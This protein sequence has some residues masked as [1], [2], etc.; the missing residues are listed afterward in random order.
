MPLPPT[1]SSESATTLQ[2]QTFGTL[3][4]LFYWMRV[5]RSS[6]RTPGMKF[7]C[8]MPGHLF[9]GSPNCEQT[10]QV[11]IL[12]IPQLHAIKNRFRRQEPIR[13]VTH[14]N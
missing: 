3:L 7:S 8:A 2:Q 4:R 1:S 12:N 14:P 13:A 10:L 6:L 9:S 5:N 11:E